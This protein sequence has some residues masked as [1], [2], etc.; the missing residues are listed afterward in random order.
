MDPK[1]ILVFINLFIM[2]FYWPLGIMTSIIS[3]LMIHYKKEKPITIKMVIAADI[4]ILC[5]SPMI[6]IVCI[7]KTLFL[8]CLKKI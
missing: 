4:L 3:I 1:I 6:G 2:L 5:V 7:V 8:W